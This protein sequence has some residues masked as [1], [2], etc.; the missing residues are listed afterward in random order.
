MLFTFDNFEVL[1]L[2]FLMHGFNEYQLCI[3][4]LGVPQRKRKIVSFR[5]QLRVLKNI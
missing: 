2:I 1:I 4:F 3:E 5:I